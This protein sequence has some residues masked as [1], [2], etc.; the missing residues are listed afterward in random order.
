MDNTTY[1]DRFTDG[2]IAILRA[3][4]AIRRHSS[5]WGE[6][7]RITGDDFDHWIVYLADE[8]DPVYTIERRDGRYRLYDYGDGGSLR[9]L[10]TTEEFAA[11]LAPLDRLHS[12]TVG[13]AQQ[14][15]LNLARAGLTWR[16]EAPT[17]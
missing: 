11:I 16:P 1:P 17:A 9:C 15:F 2:E 6:P 3:L 5:G 4:T 14:E 8:E 13:I 7:R 10:A 12:R